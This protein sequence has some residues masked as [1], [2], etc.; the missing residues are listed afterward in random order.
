MIILFLMSGVIGGIAA[1]GWALTSNYGLLSVFLAYPL[2]GMLS[3]A[4][5][6]SFKEWLG[7]SWSDPA[8]RNEN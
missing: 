7:W 3:A 6:L 2:G 5:T 4:A 8:G 1:A